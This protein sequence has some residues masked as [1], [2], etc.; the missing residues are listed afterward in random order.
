MIRRLIDLSLAHRGLVVLAGVA[1]LLAGL[2][3]VRTTPLDALPDLSDVQVIVRTPAPGMAPGLVDDQITRPLATTLMAVPGATTVRGFSYFGDSFLYVLFEEGTD[4]YWARSRVLEYLSSADVPDGITPQLGP[5]ASG[6]GWVYQYAL[7]DRTGRRAIDDL[8][9]LQDWQIRYDLQAVKGVSE[10]ATI[11]GMTRAFQVN[12]D[13]DALLAHGLTLADLAR[14]MRAANGEAAGSV[15]ELAE[16]EYM[17]RA[18]GYVST[19]EDLRQAPLKLSEDQVPVTIGDVADVGMAPTPRRGVAD[20]NGEGEAVGGIVVMRKG[21]NAAATIA[22]VK[23]AL[24]RIRDGLP[25]GVELVTTYDRSGLIDRSVATLADKIAL[26]LAI[27]ALVCA[28]FLFHG[29][30][31]L[32][33]VLT[34]PLGV[35]IAFLVMRAQGLTANIM[36][37]G[38]IAIAIG[39]MVDGPLVMIEALH[40]RLAAQEKPP[41][42]RERWALV[43]QV[44]RAVGPAIFAS[45]VIITLSFLPVFALEAQEGR[46][47]RPLAYTKTWAMAAA[48]LLSVTLVPVLMGYMVRGRVRDERANPLMRGLIALYRPALRWAVRHPWPVLA[49]ALVLGFSGAYP[50]MKLGGEFMPDLREGDFLYMPSADAGLSIGE[51][52]RLVQQTNKMIMTVPEVASAHGKA[53]RA[54]T[55]TDPAPLT[56]IETVVRLKPRDQWRDGMTLMDIRAELNETVKVPGLSNAW[57]WPIKGRIDMLTTGIKTAIGVK[58]AGDSLDRTSAA[59]AQVVSALDGLP[60]VASAYAEKSV[61][62]RYVTLMPDRRA[63]ARH[64]LSVADLHELVATGVGGRIVATSV[65]GLERTPI[66]LRLAPDARDTPQ[67]LEALVFRAPGG[68]HVRLG[69]VAEVAVE[70][71]PGLIKSEQARSLTTVFVDAAGDDLTGTVAAVRRALSQTDLPPGVTWSLAGRFEYLDRATRQLGVIVPFT[72]M[73]IALILYLLFKTWRDVGLVL[74][75]VPLSLSG[76]VWLL[77]LLDYRLSVAVAV[78]FIALFGVVVETAV[79]MVFYLRDSLRESRAESGGA[80]TPQTARDAI[81]AGALLRL[82]PL[83]MTSLT[84]LAGLLPVMWGGGTGAVV[85]Q[86]LAAPLVGGI[87]LGVLLVLFLLPALMGMTRRAGGPDT[88]K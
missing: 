18:T 21:A 26:E 82:R 81:V 72:L 30:S 9:A 50:A 60:G 40:R 29:R 51:A 63:L 45:L 13:P 70:T 3:A 80:N 41:E 17:V 53:G 15:M 57:V 4:L 59:A 33:V 14:A 28:A 38:G 24:E 19:P 77:Y 32:I 25:E 74:L 55:A 67:A 16:A 62:G 68:A 49:L 48:A 12:A 75:T 6:V 54:E 36:S 2:W 47:F 1:A 34:L 58:L 85:M 35:L 5:D 84:I 66:R 69:S 79:V 71:G 44:C 20:L 11:G 37:L 83:V 73:V 46:L 31:S 42:G 39:A 87:A 61:S 22:R 64:G 86:R 52:R 8:T 27:V 56:M 23:D 10:V 65:S 43:A 7:V 88:E 78:G 76:G